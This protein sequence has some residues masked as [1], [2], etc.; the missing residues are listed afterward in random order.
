VKTRIGFD[1]ADD[2]DRL[3]DLLARHPLD[4]V[5]VHGR[6]VSQLYRGAVRYD[7]IARAVAALPCPVLAN[8]DID[9]AAKAD[10]VLHQTGARGIMVGR[11][12]IRNP[13]IFRQIRE[14]LAGQPVFL[15][16]GREVLAY[17]QA[18]EGAFC[19][20]DARELAQVELMKKYM[21][22][23]GVGV[24]P[25]GQFLDAIRRVKTKADFFRVCADHL[26]HDHPLPLEPFPGLLERPGR[27]KGGLASWCGR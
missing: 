1:A 20:P 23:L 5:T 16:R 11:G 2:F 6:T 9:S 26:D 25:T 14:H 22:Y 13:W 3:L 15:P 8:G 27:S 17:V 10:A 4:L 18:I 7:L 21:N 24:E 19:R 12:A